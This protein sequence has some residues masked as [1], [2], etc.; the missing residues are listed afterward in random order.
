MRARLMRS[1]MRPVHRV[2]PAQADETAKRQW[3]EP[4]TG[5]RA[6]NTLVLHV[7]ARRALY[8]NPMREHGERHAK[9][10]SSGSPPEPALGRHTSL[11]PALLA[12]S[13]SIAARLI[14][15]YAAPDGA[16]GNGIS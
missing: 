12:W 15:Y 14:R 2:A 3:N 16:R 5:I 1:L 9:F 4:A 7:S 6:G 11:N 10:A 8:N 13:G